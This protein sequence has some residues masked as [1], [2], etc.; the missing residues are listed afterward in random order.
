MSNPLA[1]QLGMKDAVFLRVNF[2]QVAHTWAG[3]S[4]HPLPSRNPRGE[5]PTVGAELTGDEAGPAH[6]VLS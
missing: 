2:A 3:T 6:E 1:Y 5:M 4:L